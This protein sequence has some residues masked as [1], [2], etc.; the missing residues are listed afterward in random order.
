MMIDDTTKTFLDKL[1]EIEALKFGDFTLASGAKSNF[2]VDL[3]FLPSF[4]MIFSDIID[5]MYQ[6]IQ[7]LGAFDAIIGI[8]LAGIPFATALSLRTKKPLH[9]MRKIPKEH[10]MKKLIEG[11]SIEGKEILLIDDLISSGHSKEFAIDAIRNEGGK[12]SN[13]VVLINRASEPFDEWKKLWKISIHACYNAS[14]SVLN[15]YRNDLNQ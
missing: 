3:R 10:G 7:A 11:P 1:Q 12:V 5:K 14:Q 4:P 9:L 15:N 8:P 6:D 13:L 2:Y